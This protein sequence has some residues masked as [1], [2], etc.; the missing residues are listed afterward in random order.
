MVAEHDDE[1]SFRPETE[2]TRFL[3]MS[4]NDRRNNGKLYSNR[5]VIPLLKET[6][7]AKANDDVRFLNG[8]VSN[9]RLCADAVKTCRTVA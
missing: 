8:K 2:L 1:G 3:C 5:I 6:E 9:S 7:V 4:T